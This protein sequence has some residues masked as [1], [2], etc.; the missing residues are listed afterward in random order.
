MSRDTDTSTWA[1]CG[2]SSCGFAAGLLSGALGVVDAGASEL[3]G[4]AGSEVDGA[5]VVGVGSSSAP[6]GPANPAVSNAAAA[7]T[8]KQR[9]MGLALLDLFTNSHP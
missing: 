9:A 7:S 4:G 5:V 3:L 6:A 2:G 8:A 1:R